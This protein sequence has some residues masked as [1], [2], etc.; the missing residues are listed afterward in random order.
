MPKFHYRDGLYFERIPE[1]GAVVVELNGNRLE[2]DGPSWP[3]VIAAMSAAGEQA[4]I[5]AAK[6]FHGPTKPQPQ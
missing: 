4:N 6:E 1:T 3:S 5:E 2:V